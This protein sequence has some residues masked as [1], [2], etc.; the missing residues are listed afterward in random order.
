MPD[1]ITLADIK[2]GFRINNVKEGT[3]QLFGLQE[4]NNNKRYDLPEEGFGF[5]DNPA[6]INR[7]KNYLPV[8]VVKDTTKVTPAKG[9]TV[10]KKTRR[11]SS[12]RWRV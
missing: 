2:G 10:L 5:M 12:H 9:N 6:E 11:N 4:K 3:Y 7:T 8:V 1:Y